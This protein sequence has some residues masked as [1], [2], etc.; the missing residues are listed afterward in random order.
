MFWH[1]GRRSVPLS[2]RVVLIGIAIAFS[3]ADVPT[4]TAG[5]YGILNLGT[6]GGAVSGDGIADF[7]QAMVGQS[8]TPSGAYHAFS[9]GRLGL[10]DL[11]TLG[12]AQSAAFAASGNWIVGQAQTTNGQ[13]HAFSMDVYRASPMVDLGTLGG[14]TSAAY[15]SDYSGIVGASKTA[16]DARLLAFFRPDGGTMSALAFDWGGDS[17]ARAIAD[18]TI[19]GYACTARNASCHAFSYR[20][21]TAT[22]LKSLGGNSIA[23]A[24]NYSGQIVGT[25]FLADKT[26]S[27]AV[28]FAS[29]TVVDL[30]TLGGADSEALDI[31]NYGDIVGS[32]E[33][34]TGVKHAVLWKNGAIVDLNTLIRP[35]SGWILQTASA[36]SDAGQIVGSGTFNGAPRAFMVTPPIPVILSE[37]GVRTLSDGNL[38]R[39][40]EVG[41]SIRWVTS[42]TAGTEDPATLYGVHITNT[43]TGPAEYTGA[44][45]ASDDT[46]HITPKTVTCDLSPIDAVG[47]GNEIMVFARTTGPGHI[48]QTATV[49][50]DTA[51]VGHASISQE[52]WAVAVSGLTLTPPTIAGGKAS[53]AKVTLTDIAPFSNDATVRLASSRPDV[54][55][56]PATIVVPYGSS[57]RAFNIIPKVVSAPTTVDISATYGQV[58]VTRTLTITPPALSTLSL[59]PTTIVGGC[60]TSAGKIALTGNAPEGGAVV[61][62]SNTNGATD[63]PATITVPAGASTATFTIKTKTVT[64]PATG[65][66]TATYGGIAK[67]LDTTVRPIRA[68]TVTLSPNPVQ[69]GSTVTGTVALECAA[70]PGGI[71]VSLASS[72]SAV[73]TPTVSS[74]TIPA[75]STT[76]SFS[77]RTTRPAASTNLSIHTTVY[78]V[79]KST[80]LT[81]N[82]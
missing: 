78:S 25:S 40:V 27:H 66:V 69:G 14:T 58:T 20:D 71:V 29:A 54:A 11:G 45:S 42:A 56:V 35:N 73:A 36:I 68:K 48:V 76:A 61:T 81:V 12:G 51:D 7:G 65:K 10:R 82:P 9:Q 38:P 34:S 72:N 49:S 4:Q 44:T 16:G 80:T 41:K 18:T 47:L 17:V 67:T 21:G 8:Q 22:D 28:S 43:L 74:V 5:S 57:T 46:C 13:M 6:L 64:A 55:P 26:T 52:N 19:V 62:L 53:S 59:A 33:T 23:N 24:V 1:P 70:T 37:Y 30:G 3:R 60:G 50:S 2:L 32:A 63:V 31:N 75:G 39:G 15:G 79:R 77:I